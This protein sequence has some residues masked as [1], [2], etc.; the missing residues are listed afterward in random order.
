MEVGG[1]NSGQGV[2]LTT[3]TDILSKLNVGDVLRAQVIEAAADELLLKLLDGTTLTAASTVDIN[4]DKGDFVDFIVKSKSES[5]IFLE[6]VKKPNVKLQEE[7][8]GEL[9]KQLV[10]LGIKPDSNNLEIAGE[11]KT[12]NI[13]LTKENLMKALDMMLEFK[14][15]TPEKAAFISASDLV[16]NE[17]NISLLNA[18]TEGKLKIAAD[19][20]ELVKIISKADIGDNKLGATNKEIPI[21]STITAKEPIQSNQFSPKPIT[22]DLNPIIL[23]TEPADKQQSANGSTKIPDAIKAYFETDDKLIQWVIENKN[24]IVQEPEI[25]EHFI[26]TE[27]KQI[28]VQQLKPTV[29]FI[30]RLLKQDFTKAIKELAINPEYATKLQQGEKDPVEFKNQLLKE[31]KDVFV[32]LDSG[33]LEKDIDI[34]KLYKSLVSKLNGLHGVL[35]QVNMPGK[36]EI[37]NKIDNISDNIRFINQ[38]NSQN[39]YVQIPI[40]MG[41]HNTT[42]EL[43]ILRRNAKRKNIN[44]EDATML[45]S[46][47]TQNI[48]QIESLVSIRK[49]NVSI[50]MRVEDKQVIDLIKENHKSLY[51]LLEE[52][53]YKLVD[54]KSRLIDEKLNP[55]NVQKLAEKFLNVN[56]KGID[57]RL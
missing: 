25:L 28:P 11:M 21:Q 16:T 35:E 18:L 6:T 26:K 36:T 22:S 8:E 41:N 42:G 40:Q 3:I 7:P 39:T 53:G 33:T 15:L 1:V 2:N 56:R 12:N 48:G 43:Y 5:Q 49:K 14:N 45:L 44:P 50:N 19:L 20:Q 51:I 24:K 32:K 52:K 57:Y 27:M 13:P 38:I 23:P 37:L 4:A 34:S 17:K 55:V 30:N 29:D 47:S 9:K 46:L 10:S 54:L 31:I